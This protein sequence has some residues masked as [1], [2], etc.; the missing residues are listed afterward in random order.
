MNQVEDRVAKS[1]ANEAGGRSLWCAKNYLA[2]KIKSQTPYV[3]FIPF[4]SMATD[5]PWQQYLSENFATDYHSRR[6]SKNLSGRTIKKNQHVGLFGE[7]SMGLGKMYNAKSRREMSGKP[8]RKIRVKK[9]PMMEMDETMDKPKTAKKSSTRKSKISHITVKEEKKQLKIINDPK[10]RKQEMREEEGRRKQAQTS[11]KKL[12]RQ[13]ID[14]I[15]KSRARVTDK[16]DQIFVTQER[17][18][19]QAPTLPNEGDN[20]VVTLERLLTVAEQ[21]KRDEPNPKKKGTLER[22]IQKL[23]TQLGNAKRKAT[24][25]RQTGKVNK[26]EAKLSAIKRNELVTDFKKD[27]EQVHKEVR[28]TVDA[29]K[30]HEKKL[31]SELEQEAEKKEFGVEN[32]LQKRLLEVTNQIE[33]EKTRL[34]AEMEPRKKG[35][36]TMKINKLAAELKTLKG[37]LTRQKNMQ[38]SKKGSKGKGA[39]KGT[40]TKSS[41]KSKKSKK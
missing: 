31:M 4:D 26:D 29:Q 5:N 6:A 30:K 25:A 32:P 34:Q 1:P 27:M 33:L 9:E 22:K 35:S 8:A 41:T 20:E 11:F 10:A 17:H 13:V 14:D 18:A 15:R 37:Q 12:A 39:G 28:N 21:A 3:V 38:A 36:I 2:F 40:S 16:V 19:A 7:T 24:M 23:R